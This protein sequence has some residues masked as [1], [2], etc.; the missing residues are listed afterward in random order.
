MAEVTSVL[1][2][3]ETDIGIVY[4]DGQVCLTLTY[5]EAQFLKEL[6]NRI[7]TGSGQVFSSCN[8]DIYRALAE[9]D[10]PDVKRRVG[11]TQ[12]GSLSSTFGELNDN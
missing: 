6:M 2:P 5:R 3:G 12:L 9:A 11:F 1:N 4:P 7:A 8:W 10:I